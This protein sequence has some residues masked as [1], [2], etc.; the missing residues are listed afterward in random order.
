MILS[1][2]FFTL[3]LGSGTLQASG[4]DQPSLIRLPFVER[5]NPLGGFTKRDGYK[6]SLYNSHG[7]QYLVALSIGTPGQ[8][9]TV[10]LDT[11]R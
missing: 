7:N 2:L 6:S 8:K 11:G 10:T 5:V 4:A 3:V 9:F 1:T